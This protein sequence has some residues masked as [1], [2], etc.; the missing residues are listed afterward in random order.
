MKKRLAALLLAPL[1]VLALLFLSG[2]LYFRLLQLWDQMKDVDRYFVF[3]GDKE[4]IISCKTPIMLAQDLR[5]MI[6]ASPDKKYMDGPERGWHYDFNMVRHTPLAE[7]APLE[8]LSLDLRFNGEY[9]LTRLTIPEE[10]L[11]IFSKDVLAETMK[12]A[13]HAELYEMKRLVRGRVRLPPAADA[14][15]PD[16][17]RTDALLG[18]PLAIREEEHGAQTLIYRYRIAGAERPVPIIARLTFAKDGLLH[19]VHVTWDTA[20]VDAE[21]VRSD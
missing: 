13:A 11:R 19:R 7:P 3:S 9:K 12:Q 2:C 15:L 21:F 8:N 4:L 20:A 10:F 18:P 6:G 16:R 5:L 14:Q 17:S 1:A